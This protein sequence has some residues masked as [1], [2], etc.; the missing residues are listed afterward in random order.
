M[1]PVCS[2]LSA[3]RCAEASVRLALR[4]KISKE[5]GD[6]SAIS[7]LRLAVLLLVRWR[8]CLIRSSSKYEILCPYQNARARLIL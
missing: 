5:Y 3:P 2:R 1:T 6:I 7:D 8:T 4:S